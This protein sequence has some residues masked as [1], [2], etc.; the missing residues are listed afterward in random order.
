MRKG[1]EAGTIDFTRK[2]PNQSLNVSKVKEVANDKKKKKFCAFTGS[3][4]SS[5]ND[6]WP[7]HSD[8]HATIF[9]K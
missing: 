2:L 5:L 9:R 3:N 6:K 4:A 1:D 7:P 8:R